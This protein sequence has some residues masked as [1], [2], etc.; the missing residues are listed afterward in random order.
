MLGCGL[1]KNH[2]FFISKSFVVF[3]QIYFF[4]A[5]FSTIGLLHYLTTLLKQRIIRIIVLFIYEL[6]EYK[7]GTHTWWSSSHYCF[8]H[9]QHP[10]W[11]ARLNNSNGINRV[12]RIACRGGSQ[13]LENKVSSWQS[14]LSLNGSTYDTVRLHICHRDCTFLDKTKNILLQYTAIL[15]QVQEKYWS[16]EL[17]QNLPWTGPVNIITYFQ[18]PTYPSVKRMSLLLLL[19]LLL[20]HLASKCYSSASASSRGAASFASVSS[21]LYAST[22][23]S[24]TSPAARSSKGCP[25]CFFFNYFC[26]VCLVTLV[27][28]CRIRNLILLPFVRLLNSML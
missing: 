10:L 6:W 25:Y 3:I 12:T 5:S 11:I 13:L 8:V 28:C 1:M 20:L 22:D 21:A 19:Q 18:L 4:S 17:H 9:F 24:A 16:H 23:S 15:E 7:P 27:S 14:S 2:S 26:F